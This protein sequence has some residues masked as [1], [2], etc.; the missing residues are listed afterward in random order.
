MAREFLVTEP[1][2]DF[3]RRGGLDHRRREQGK[4]KQDGLQLVGTC[5]AFCMSAIRVW[6]WRS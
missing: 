4:Q 2:G 6:G 5:S 3:S 1:P